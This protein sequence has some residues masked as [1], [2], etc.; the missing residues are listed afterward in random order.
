MHYGQDDVSSAKAPMSLNNV[1]SSEEFSSE[2]S[3]N[4]YEIARALERLRTLHSILYRKV[5]Q[6]TGEFPVGGPEQSK[7]TNG[8]IPVLEAQRHIINALHDELSMFE[9][10][11]QQS[12]SI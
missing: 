7:G 12:T 4:T 8:P 10:V 3:N 1:R 9:Q 11:V 5:A 6:L 2:F